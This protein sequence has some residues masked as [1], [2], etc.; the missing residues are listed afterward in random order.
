[1]SGSPVFHVEQYPSESLANLAG[2]YI[3]GDDAKHVGCLVDA[4]ILVDTLDEAFKRQGG[5]PASSSLD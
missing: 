5:Q 4:A 3:K 1:M 2:I